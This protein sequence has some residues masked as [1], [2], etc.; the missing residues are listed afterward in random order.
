MIAD[1]IRDAG[2]ANR[3]LTMV[4]RATQSCQ[5][6]LQQMRAVLEFLVGSSQRQENGIRVDVAGAFNAAETRMAALER[7]VEELRAGCV[8][9]ERATHEGIG[10]MRADWEI[11]KDEWACLRGEFN[12]M[13]K[14]LAEFR[15]M[16]TTESSV[17]QQS[18]YDVQARVTGVAT[19]VR[20]NND[21]LARLSGQVATLHTELASTKA[22]VEAWGEVPV[23]YP[24]EA[25]SEQML[26]LIAQNQDLNGRVQ[27][28]EQ[29]I[30]VASAQQLEIPY[31]QIDAR[32]AERARAIAIEIF[33]GW[34]MDQKRMTH[35]EAPV[36][37][38]AQLPPCEYG[39][40]WNVPPLCDPGRKHHRDASRAW[41]VTMRVS[42]VT[43]PLRVLKTIPERSWQQ[44][45]QLNKSGSGRVSVGGGNP[46]N[47]S[48]G[49]PPEQ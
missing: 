26:T 20:Q 4:L 47:L 13:T 14:E 3:E 49:I 24:R 1:A 35:G 37:P 8:N 23:T 6:D 5:T 17:N 41:I 34:L 31:D 21:S 10:K 12:R 33:N 36:T 27:R 22:E 2:D 40:G 38:P 45:A 42:W 44:T 28:M 7:T 25:P 11:K 46:G 29:A 32:I 18:L 48:V 39:E 30:P 9:L 43:I 19:T 16:V 15:S